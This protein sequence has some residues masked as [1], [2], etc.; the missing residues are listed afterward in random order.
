MVYFLT[1]CTRNKCIPFKL[2]D[3]YYYLKPISDA[4][5]FTDFKAFFILFPNLSTF[6]YFSRPPSANQHLIFLHQ[7]RPLAS[8]HIVSNQL[9]QRRLFTVKTKG[10]GSIPPKTVFIMTKKT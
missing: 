10:P 8:H 7:L 2:L 3:P 5:T 1:P 9:L 6:L 4:T